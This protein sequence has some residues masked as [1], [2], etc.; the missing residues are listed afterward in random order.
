[1]QVRLVWP[2]QALLLDLNLN[3]KLFYLSTISMKILTSWSCFFIFLCFTSKCLAQGAVRSTTGEGIPISWATSCIP[4]HLNAQG[5][6]RLPISEIEAV[7]RRSAT[8]WSDPNCARMSLVYEGESTQTELGYDPDLGL[9]NKNMVIFLS[10]KSGHT[11]PHDPNALALTTVTFCENDTPT[12]PAGTIVD[13]DIE[14]NEVLY[15]F[16]TNDQGSL[17]DLENTLTH[18]LGHLLGFEHSTQPSSTMFAVAPAGERTK[19]DLSNDDIAGLCN[20]Y[21]SD[22]CLTCD[23]TTYDLNNRT[24]F[25]QRMSCDLSELESASQTSGCQQSAPSMSSCILFILWMIGFGYCRRSL[26]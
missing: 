17:N 26:C 21:A 24:E 8:T 20:A 5:R 3:F 2:S 4:L 16:S 25:E 7:M 6:S 19:R 18:E 14:M 15:L 9:Q 12:C 1:M 11:W 23:F 13:A 10:Q 22:R